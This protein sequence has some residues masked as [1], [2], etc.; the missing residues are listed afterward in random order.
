MRA[1]RGPATA[2]PARGEK[3]GAF[4]AADHGAPPAPP[5]RGGG[6]GGR[7]RR[8]GGQCVERGRPLGSLI[9]H[10]GP[11]RALM[12]AMVKT[13]FR[14]LAMSLARR[15]GRRSACRGATRRRAV[16]VPTITRGADRKEA[17]AEAADFLTKRGVHVGGG[18]ARF[19]WTRWSNRG[20][21]ETTGS[22]AVGASRGSPRV[23][24]YQLQ[25]L[26]SFAAARS[27]RHHRGTVQTPEGYGR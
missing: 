21:K 11:I 27:V 9:P 2:A 8:A 3:P 19:D 22:V 25:A 14:A 26:T 12:I 5:P 4:A 24:R 7:R 18:A 17:V 6:R 20:T 1:L 10:A 16:R 13:P 23:W 15:P